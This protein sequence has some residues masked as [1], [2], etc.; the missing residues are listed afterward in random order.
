[1]EEGKEVGERL[2]TGKLNIHQ[3]ETLKKDLLAFKQQLL[4]MKVSV[5]AENQSKEIS[6]RYLHRQL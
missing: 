5:F 3:I 1:M 4:H 2:Q 6:I